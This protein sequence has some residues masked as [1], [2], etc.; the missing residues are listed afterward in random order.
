MVVQHHQSSDENTALTRARLCFFR[1]SIPWIHYSVMGTMRTQSAQLLA[2]VEV[3]ESVDRFC[4]KLS[5]IT[6]FASCFTTL[7]GDLSRNYNC[8][9]IFLSRQSYL[10]GCGMVRL[11]WLRTH[12]TKFY[13]VV[14]WPILY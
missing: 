13:L 4:F 5:R 10:M 6:T 14:G 7:N 12:D 8:I 9:D 2:L 11:S 3:P 1:E